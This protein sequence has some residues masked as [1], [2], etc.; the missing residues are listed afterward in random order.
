MAEEE[1]EAEST[2]KDPTVANLAKATS[3]VCTVGSNR[4][5]AVVSCMVKETT[6]GDCTVSK[7][8]MGS[9]ASLDYRDT[10]VACTVSRDMDRTVPEAMVNLDY[11]DN[12]ATAAVCTANLDMEAACMVKRATEIACMEAV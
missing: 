3:V 12:P 5:M 7:V 11:M 2:T 8:D 10:E 4:D 1:E 9:T 6:V